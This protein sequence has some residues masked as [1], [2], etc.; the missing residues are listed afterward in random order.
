[1][2]IIY[3]KETISEEGS[4][5]L[6]DVTRMKTHFTSN[7]SING[8]IIFI[9]EISIV[10]FSCYDFKVSFLYFLEIQESLIALLMVFYKDNSAIVSIS[11]Q[12]CLYF[13]SY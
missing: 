3:C 2:S 11:A 10:C 9:A 8:S 12:F 6:F 7:R 13:R 4:G 1:M 5:V